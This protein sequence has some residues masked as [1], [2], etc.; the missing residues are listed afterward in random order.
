MRILILLVLVFVVDSGFSQNNRVAIFD[1]T[2]KSAETT[3]GN[4]F[5]VEHLLKV[6]GLPYIVTSDFSVATQ[7]K[8]IV[9]TSNIETNTFTPGEVTTIQNFVSGGGV[10]VATQLKDP[11][12]FN[13]FGVSGYTYGTRRFSF[14]F[15]T[16]VEPSVFRWIDDANEKHILL[17][18]TTKNTDIIGTRAYTLSTASQL[19]T[20]GEGTTGLSKNKSNDGYAYLLGINW[21]D[22]VLRNQVIASFDAFRTYSNG[23]EPGTDVFMLILK[24]IYTT[25]NVFSVWKHTSGLDSKA[26]L[27]ITHDVDATSAIKDMMNNFAA[28]EL[29]NGIRATYFVTTHYMHDSLAKDFWHGYT[30]DIIALKTRNHEIAS[31]SVSHVPDFDNETIVLAGSEGNTELTYAPFYNGHFSNNVTVHGETEVSKLLLERITGLTIRSYR[32]GY[33]LYHEE[34]LN[35]LAEKNYVF[36]SS[37]SANNVLTAFPFFGHFDL[38]MSGELSNVLEIPNTISDVFMANPISETNYMDKVSIWRDVQKRNAANFAPTVLLIHPNRT[39]KI[40]AEQS[41]IRNLS[42]KTR[43]VPFEHFGNFWK[44]REAT[45]FDFVESP[46]S[47]I[48]ITIK[49]SSLPLHEDLSFVLDNGQSAKLITVKDENGNSIPLTK[50]NWT[51]NG[52]ILHSSSFSET[53]DKFEYTNTLEIS[54]FQLYPNPT[55][56][57]F[58]IDFDLM[59]NGPVNFSLFDSKGALVET[60]IDKVLS[61]GQQTYSYESKT[62]TSGVYYYRLTTANSTRSGKI[63][64]TR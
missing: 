30:D 9:F 45:Q 7:S 23:F 44:A 63:L 59:T 28:Y 43:I 2:A 17:G 56:G 46:D 64:V 8:I 21:R 37:L 34:L 42:D 16:S 57:T 32:T 33:L 62:L 49:N 10:I 13:L 48:T 39:W 1:L 35:I 52:I 40:T 61:I 50:S 14:N 12:L 41:F 24:G 55:T 26:S 5:S 22:V 58:T 54:D 53:Y 47:V 29:E 20:F 36:N 4:L 19:G 11:R 60:P 38:S 15:K 18:D 51:D 25:H 6:S 31:H 27:I 3:N